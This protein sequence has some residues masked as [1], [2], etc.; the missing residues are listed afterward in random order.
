[1]TGCFCRRVDCSFSRDYIS[2]LGSVFTDA[3]RATHPIVLGDKTAAKGKPV[4][5]DLSMFTR[6]NPV[7]HWLW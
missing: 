7:V 3:Q 4:Q 1:M 2:M 6:A 5:C